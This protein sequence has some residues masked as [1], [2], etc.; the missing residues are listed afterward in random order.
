[1]LSL[2]VAILASYTALDLA[3]R[4]TASR[5]APR[6]ALADRRRVRD[7]HRHL[8]DA[9]HRHARVQPADPDGL[10]RADHAALD[11]DRD[12]SSPASRCS[13]S[14]ATR[15]ATGNLS[16]GGVL[17]GIGICAMHYTG[18]AAM[19]M[20]P[21]DRLRPAGCSPPRSRSRS[22]RR[23]PRSGS[24]SRCA[25]D[26]NWMI[27]AKLGSA[28]IMG[29]AITGMHYT[30]MAA[31]RF[32]PRHDL[33]DRRELVDNSWMAGTIAGGH[34]RHPVR[35]AGALGV[36]TRAW[37]RERRAWQPRCRRRTRSCSA[38]RCTTA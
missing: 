27:Y 4:I 33:P 25:R 3:T 18:M 29:L 35:H 37:P 15:S 9:L 14:A 30:G 19:E 36:S 34:L 32:A 26:A 7:G 22:S 38:W 16:A 6:A 5:A 12:A 31:A 10:R 13:R 11:A 2:L 24:R 8:V 23:S 28:V 20:S 21:A 17:M 1:M